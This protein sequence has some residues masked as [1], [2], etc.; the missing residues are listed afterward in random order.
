[1][2]P[3]RVGTLN[4]LGLAVYERADS[5]LYF[6]DGGRVDLH[7]NTKWTTTDAHPLGAHVQMRG[8]R[9]LDRRGPAFRGASRGFDEDMRRAIAASMEQALIPSLASP[10]RGTD[11]DDTELAIA[12]AVSLEDAHAVPSRDSGGPSSDG[13]TCSICMD[14]L[15]AAGARALRCGMCSARISFCRKHAQNPPTPAHKPFSSPHRPLFP[16]LVHQSLVSY[17]AHMPHMPRKGV[18]EC[19]H[20]GG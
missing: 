15:G 12:I 10:A 20:Q 4:A 19:K 13:P 8:K 18:K 14:T 3:R 2:P 7:G 1:M 5:S 6:N 16:R 11:C 9:P 17:L